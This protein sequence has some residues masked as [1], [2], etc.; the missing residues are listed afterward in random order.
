MMMMRRQR[1]VS[2]GG[3]VLFTL[4]SYTINTLHH[5]H[6]EENDDDDDDGHGDDDDEE[7]DD[8]IAFHEEET[9][10]KYHFGGVENVFG[11]KEF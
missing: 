5:H 11:W 4:H 1:H 3:C 10:L 7:D 6:H 8:D 2:M 9:D